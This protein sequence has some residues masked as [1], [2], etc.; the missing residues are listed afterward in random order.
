MFA[1]IPPRVAAALFGG[2]AAGVAFTTA[3]EV[4]TAP[5]STAVSLYQ[6][7]GVVHMVKVV[8]LVMFVI[9]LLGVLAHGGYR[10]GLVGKGAGLALAGAT[11]LG[12]VPYTVIESSMDPGLTPAAADAR[13]EAIYADHV[14][15]G[16]LASVAMPIIVLSVVTLAVVVMRR[17]LL[18]IWAPLCSLLAIPV[19]I[20]AIVISEST[21]VALPH[22]PAWIF[23]GLASYAAAARA[24]DGASRRQMHTQSV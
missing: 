17:R 22:P 5:Y 6:L 24:A 15:V 13:L 8:A 20:V 1:H 11:T 18:P 2:G 9:G 12:A 3:L 7:N 21:G 10:L 23:L 16:V 14:W 19:A 4:F